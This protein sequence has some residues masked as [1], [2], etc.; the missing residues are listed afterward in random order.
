MLNVPAGTC[1]PKPRVMASP[2]PEAMA[3]RTVRRPAI[4]SSGF[5]ATQSELLGRGAVA[6]RAGPYMQLVRV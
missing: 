1:H 2:K 6:L 4:A 3:S 5:P